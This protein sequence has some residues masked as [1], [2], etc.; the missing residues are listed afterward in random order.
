MN[1]LLVSTIVLGCVARGDIFEDDLALKQAIEKGHGHGM[2]IGVLE[3]AI[4]RPDITLK[5]GSAGVK[6]NLKQATG[7]RIRTGVDE[8]MVYN[9]LW[10]LEPTNLYDPYTSVIDFGFASSKFTSRV[11]Y[12]RWSTT[13]YNALTLFSYNFIEL[14]RSISD[15]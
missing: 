4:A 8:T 10:T 11:D 9:F 7:W 15:L 1:K 12:T 6:G 14:N 5:T 13:I 3:N 2:K